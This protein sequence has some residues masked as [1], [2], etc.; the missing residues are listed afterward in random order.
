MRRLCLNL[1]SAGFAAL[2]IAGLTA[3]ALHSV[4]ALKPA[5]EEAVAAPAP[6]A[7]VR[8]FGVY[9]DPWHLDEWTRG[10]GAAPQLVA[11]FEAF[12]Q[13][14]TVDA[15]LGESQ[16]R[17]I[18]RVMV[19]WEPWRPVPASLGATAQFAPQPGYRNSDIARGVQ[20]A[21]ITRFATSLAAFPGQVDLRWAH[22]MNG[23]WYPWSRDATGYR[24]AWRR[25][26][27]LFRQAGARNVRFVW[28]VNPNLYQRRKTWRRVTRRYWPGS[29]YVDALGM[30][31][32][33]FGGVKDYRVARFVPRLAELRASYRRPI[34]LTEVNTDY[35]GR[36]R[37]LRDLRRLL[38][39]TPGISAVYWS[40]LPS[41]GTAHLKDAGFLDWDVQRDPA[42]AAQLRNIIRDGRR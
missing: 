31:M 3:L 10:V 5:Q 30:T 23:R 9:V 41:R 14:R 6:S 40:Q 7:G 12:S 37:W 16:R 13:N 36:V 15:F 21:Y 25:I 39:R 42:A 1:T 26:V 20:D 18:R 33:D 22:E 4:P 11:K 32:I 8:P 38:R 34:V 35:H 19:S 29:G 28:S 17:G 24:A 27:R 2:L